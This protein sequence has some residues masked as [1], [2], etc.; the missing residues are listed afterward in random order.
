MSIFPTIQPK[1]TASTPS[2]TQTLPMAEEV[3]WDFERNVPVFRDGWP[4]SVTGREAVKV[5]IWKALHTKRFIHA[6]YS[7]NY[8]CDIYRLIGQT[9]TLQL[10]ETEAARYIR[11]CLLI[12]RYITA[13]RN[14]DVTFN[15]AKLTIAC[16]VD[17]IYGEVSATTDV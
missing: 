16:T 8:G 13:V 5:W 17:T 4:L 10:K 3:M 12:N 11:E 9:Y 15:A 7:Y 14:V 1:P 6:I 2:Q